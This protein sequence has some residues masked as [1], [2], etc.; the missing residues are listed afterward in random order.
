MGAVYEADH[1]A[2]GRKVAVKVLSPELSMRQEAVERFRREAL[3]A[4][5]L[6]HPNIIQIQDFR[7]EEGA[8]AFLVMELLQGE[9]LAQRI[10]RLGTLSDGALRDIAHQVLD[11]LTAAH[12]AGIVHRD[13]KPENLFLTPVGTGDVVKVLDFGVAKLESDQRITREGMLV[14]SPLYMAP[15]QAYGSSVDARADLY[16]L[17]AT[18]YHART[19]VPPFDADTLPRILVLL[20]EAPLIPVT[21]RI[22]DADPAFAA[23]LER[24]LAKRPDERFASAAAMR[25]ALL[26]LPA[27][28]E[29][30]AR[31]ECSAFRRAPRRAPEGLDRAAAVD[32]RA[33]T[34][35]SPAG[36][37]VPMAPIARN[38]QIAV[39]QP[40]SG[41]ASSFTPLPVVPPPASSLPQTLRQGEAP[42][43]SSSV[44][45]VLLA[46]LL[47]GAGTAGT[48]AYLQSTDH[49]PP[50]PSSSTAPQP[51][52]PTAGTS[53]GKVAAKAPEAPRSEDAGTRDARDAG[54]IV[55]STGGATGK[56]VCRF[57]HAEPTYKDARDAEATLQ[58]AAGSFGACAASACGS[59]SSPKSAYYDL[60]IRST[61]AVASV[62]PSGDPCPAFDACLTSPLRSL[63]F[64]S[65]DSPGVVRIVCVSSN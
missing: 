49:A 14:G 32:P 5:R 50:A 18:L 6:G 29:P 40:V 54:G 19:G 21:V 60:Q 16:S 38:P 51:L 62:K 44:L 57:N 8:A 53:T 20:K 41:Q 23:W 15:E 13:I 34:L 25:D 9:T 59:A 35:V 58:A 30:V 24:A 56:V 4:A 61:G 42:K 31:W 12:A 64:P 27:F 26:A 46:I 10:D 45:F 36:G 7:A 65:P 47:G 39:V 1:E 52:K 37:T 22:P 3:A 63:A 17:G 43:S 48:W 33:G 11:A 28:R 2:L 55:L